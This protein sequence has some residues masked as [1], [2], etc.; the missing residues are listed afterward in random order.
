MNQEV[1]NYAWQI[2]QEILTTKSKAGQKGQKISE[3]SGLR[4]KMS[5]LAEV[6]EGT[7]SLTAVNVSMFLLFG[8]V[9]FY[10][11]WGLEW[12]TERHITQ[13]LRSVYRNNKHL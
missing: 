12:I 3:G 1:Y 4:K 8:I 11:G 5:S 2:Y 6:S 13:W 9:L 7:G 10:F